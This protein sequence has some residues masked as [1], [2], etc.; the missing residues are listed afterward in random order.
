MPRFFLAS[1]QCGAA[2]LIAAAIPNAWAGDDV[3]D[4]WEKYKFGMTIEQVRAVPGIAWGETQTE[5]V[6]AGEEVIAKFTFLKATAP[7][8]IG[9]HAY[10]LRIDFKPDIGLTLIGFE[11]KTAAKSTTACERRFTDALG[12]LER[13]HGQFT[14]REKVGKTPTPFGALDLTWHNAPTGS[15]TYE[16]TV[17]TMQF[18]PKVQLDRTIVSSVAR[19]F[20]N[21]LVALRG[22]SPDEKNRCEVTINYSDTS[23]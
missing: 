11:D 18:E 17:A 21:K 9:T 12:A 10:D 16:Y 7:V 1:F 15:S 4:G 2:M 19:K 5:E 3:L 22:A 13:R 6:K 23:P 14:A 20:G 8:K